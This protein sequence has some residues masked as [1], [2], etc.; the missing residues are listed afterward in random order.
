MRTVFQAEENVPEF[1]DLL[2]R[3]C[4]GYFNMNRK[5]HKNFGEILSGPHCRFKFKV[6]S[7][8]KILERVILILQL[9]IDELSDLRFI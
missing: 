5:L 3:M 7:S 2:N 8:L 6:S 1:R 9:E 4:R